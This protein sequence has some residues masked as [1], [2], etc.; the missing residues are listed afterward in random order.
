MNLF[1]E[2][3]QT[4]TISFLDRPKNKLSQILS[5]AIKDSRAKIPENVSLT[6]YTKLI[7]FG[8]VGRKMGGFEEWFVRIALPYFKSPLEKL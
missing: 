4:I 7:K 2:N 1:H 8:Q 5:Q 3:D 6:L